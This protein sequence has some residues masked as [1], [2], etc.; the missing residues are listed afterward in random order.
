MFIILKKKQVILV[1]LVV[2]AIILSTGSCI[3]FAQIGTPSK[4]TTT[5]EP[6]YM[7][8][9]YV[10]EKKLFL[11]EGD[12][13]F[14]QYPIASGKPGWPSPIGE[15]KIIEKS[16]WG[17]GFGGRWLGLNVPWGIYG[18]HGTSDESSIGRN[19]S[20][21]CVRMYN[22]DI[23]ELYKIVPVGT[24]VIIRNGA[25]GPFGTGFRN[26][27][28]GDRGADVLAVQMRLKELDLYKGRLDGIYGEGMKAAVHKFQKDNNLPV[29][30]TITRDDLHAMGFREFE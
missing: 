8:L 29:E 4:H 2:L 27:N 18:I 24:P 3:I 17:E 20:H 30:N 14:K 12:K 19:A 23:R 10:D 9:I 15:W 13:L 25:Y 6:K 16:D 11:F 28:P 22:K 26:I 7:I 5:S 21:G 1:V